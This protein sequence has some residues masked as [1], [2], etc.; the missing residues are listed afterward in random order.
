MSHGV[1]SAIAHA[2]MAAGAEAGHRIAGTARRMVASARAAWRERNAVKVLSTLDDRTLKD[3][4]IHRS[5]IPYLARRN[6]VSSGVN[7]R[8]LLRGR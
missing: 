7:Y 8:D 3:I 2:A 5:E 6:A 1:F 4:G